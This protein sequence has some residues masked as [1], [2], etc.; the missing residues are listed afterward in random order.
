MLSIVVR[1]DACVHAG[2]EF[3]IVTLRALISTAA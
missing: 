3:T 2:V 1:L